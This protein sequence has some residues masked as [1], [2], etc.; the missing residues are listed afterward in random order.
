MLRKG[1]MVSI[2]VTYATAA[3]TMRSISFIAFEIVLRR[4]KYGKL[5]GLRIT[6]SCSMIICL[7]YG[8]LRIGKM[9]LCFALLFGGFSIEGMLNALKGSY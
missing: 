8:A 7:G 4:R 5:I 2:L 1:D 9:W 6:S 3:L